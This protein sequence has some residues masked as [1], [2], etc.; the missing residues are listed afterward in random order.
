MEVLDKSFFY[1][2]RIGFEFEFYSSFSKTEVAE[3]LG[4]FIGKSI[5]V[6]NR[7]H[8]MFKPNSHTFKLESD[9]SGG[10][11]MMELVTGPMNYF[12]AIPVL[13]RILKWIDQFGYT[14]D[15]CALQFGLDF[16]RDKYP[17]I[18]VFRNLNPLKFVLSVD[19]DYIWERFPDR[20]NCIY[21]KSIKRINP[22]N[23]FVNGGN[24]MMVDRNS[25][26]VHTEKNMGVNLLK[27]EQGYIEIRYMGGK[28]Y[29]K[30]YTT[31]KEVIDYIIVTTFNCL[32]DNDS[33][34][35]GEVSELKSIIDGIYRSS[36]TFIDTETFIRNYPD[37]KVFIDLKND[38]QTLKSF[39]NSIKDIL[40]H[41][42]VDNGIT[43]GY[44]NYDT[45][46]SRFQLK[47]GI[48]SR[49]NLL[50]ELDLID[51]EITG[52]IANCRIFGSKLDGCQIEDSSFVSNTTTMNSKITDCDL[53]PTNHFE[54][55]YIDAK[56]KDINADVEGGII[57][58]GFIG[59]QASIS[60][61]TEIVPDELDEKGKKDKMMSR[62]LFMD[63]NY[64]ESNLPEEEPID[65]N[66][67][68][69]RFDASGLQPNRNSNT[70]NI[71]R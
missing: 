22:V 34:T 1:S 42:I 46:I 56:G 41:L 19:E 38:I 32:R 28:D 33:F 5:R 3:K 7:Y 57:R 50:K 43:S 11:K 23:R 59:P 51:C 67:M 15:K 18:T 17:L 14:D 39:F 65:L 4:G 37:L 36:E 6:F 26:S 66:D 47:D 25:Y 70:N 24:S 9:F 48:T 30:K 64:P 35:P 49:A 58:S 53:N 40:Y 45:Q 8:S 31:I 54:N 44:L 68:K 60:D 10:V 63:R 71:F 2:A 62:G 21:A 20:K 16:D 27:L 61:S 69:N 13:I 55:C 52:N 29:Q 12:E